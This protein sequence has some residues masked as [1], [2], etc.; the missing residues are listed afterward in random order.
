MIFY[1]PHQWAFPNDNNNDCSQ[2]TSVL[3]NHEFKHKFYIEVDD[4]ASLST[5][6]SDIYAFVG[7]LAP[8]KWE[9]EAGGKVLY[10]L[11]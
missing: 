6:K 9:N 2:G 10:N 8:P 7:P 1:G 3:G 4:L 11:N 5:Q